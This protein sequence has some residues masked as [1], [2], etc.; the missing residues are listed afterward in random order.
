MAQK[1]RTHKKLPKRKNQK[2]QP[3]LN[4]YFTIVFAVLLSFFIGLVV[5]AY[6]Y[7]DS[8]Q[9]AV[10]TKKE[11]IQKEHLKKKELSY[12]EKTK[13]LNIEYD[14]HNT[15]VEEIVKKIKKEQPVFHYE[16]P[17]YG[18]VD[19]ILQ[20]G[21]NLVEEIIPKVKEKV[22]QVF[23]STKKEI[24]QKE[25]KETKPKLVIIID[26][27]TTK[28]Q[29]NKI[30]DIG[31][32]VNASLLPHTKRHPN[33]A[34]IAKYLEHHMI[35]LPLQASSFRYEEAD[36]L[37]LGDSLERIENKIA[38]VKQL[39][40]KVKYI[41]N[42]T[43]SKFTSDY[44]AM[45]KLFYVLKKNDYYFIDSRTT[46]KTVAKALA[47]KYNLKMYSRDIF[48]DN[49]KETTYIQGQLKKAIKKAKKNGMA[50]AI[51]HPYSVTLETLKY[52]KSLLE[53]LD[54]IYI[55]KL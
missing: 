21:E 36:T 43:G 1:R 7:L 53:G 19:E 6:F 47:K 18:K 34:V 44:E 24:I 11:Q 13:A 55:D 54:L 23:T 37:H 3:F 39:Y 29:I 22:E 49:K 14:D 33:S 40:P 25:K 9:L 32:T 46:A 35:H 4:K 26:D 12:E 51:G 15:A 17:D 16:E 28:R 2:K 52:S 5:G 27:V 38:S 10:D 45:D 48:L 8:G 31:Y 30:K 41:N 20:E 50:I 42:H